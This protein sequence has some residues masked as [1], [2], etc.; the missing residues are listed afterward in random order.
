MDP[1][2]IRSVPLLTQATTTVRKGGSGKQDAVQK[3]SQEFEALFIQQMFQS[4]RQSI[5]EGGLLKKDN[6]TRI[7]EEM[8]D[9]ERARVMAR[10]QSLGIAD[11]I[12]RQVQ[13]KK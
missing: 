5:P 8:L 9:A 10:Q 7:Y 11:A 13:R 2:P 6:A 12:E 4:M 3:T 1:L